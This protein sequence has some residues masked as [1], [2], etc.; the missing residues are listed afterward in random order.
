MFKSSHL[1]ANVGMK[2]MQLNN[3]RKEI[4]YSRHTSMV[5]KSLEEREYFKVT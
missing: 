5:A 4:V 2:A 3:K 1:I